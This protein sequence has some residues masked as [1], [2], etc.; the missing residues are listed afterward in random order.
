MDLDDGTGIDLNSWHDGII[1]WLEDRTTE[2]GKYPH[3]LGGT[4]HAMNLRAV[5][6]IIELAKYGQQM[7][8]RNGGRVKAALAVELRK[9]ADQIDGDK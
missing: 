7:K 1:K 2:L 8:K 5:S 9:L 3:R 6:Q 4:G